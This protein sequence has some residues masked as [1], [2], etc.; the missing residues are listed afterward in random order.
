MWGCAVTQ[1]LAC[2]AF[3]R[4][5]TWIFQRQL[6]HK[7][8]IF[9]YGSFPPFKKPPSWIFSSLHCY[10]WE[11][12][13]FSRLSDRALTMPG[14]AAGLLGAG[15]GACSQLVFPA[16]WL[17]C[18]AA[19]SRVAECLCT[20]RSPSY[21]SVWRMRSVYFAG[22]LCDLINYCLENILSS[23]DTLCICQILILFLMLW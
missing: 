10:F 15:S 12:G 6:Y 18:P 14:G 23:L 8:N 7:T 9:T 2:H 11:G 5:G 17:R 16:A 13:V 3:W 20:R 21:L 1:S 22:I 4:A 19:A